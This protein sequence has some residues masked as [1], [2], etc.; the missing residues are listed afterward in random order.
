MNTENLTKTTLVGGALAAIAASACCLGPLV[1]VSLGIGGAW[2]S[3]LTLL[4]PFR[5]AFIAL[6]LACMALAYRK[7]YRAPA[8][9]NCQPGTLCAMPETNK[10]YRSMFWIV[11]MLVLVALVYPYFVPL[12]V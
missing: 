2:I 3:N 10:R 5:P 4:E 8:V 6:A 7:I 12:F 1:L 11:S 9:E